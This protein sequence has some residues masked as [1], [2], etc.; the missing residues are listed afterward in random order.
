VVCWGYNFSWVHAYLLVAKEYEMKEVIAVS[1]LFIPLG[2][3]LLNDRVEET[4]HKLD[5][6][7]RGGLFIVCAV[8][9]WLYGHSYFASFFLSIAIFFMFFDYLINII[10]LR[11][12]DWYSFLGTTSEVDKVKFWKDMHPDHRFITRA[13]LFVVCIVWYVLS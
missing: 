8:T 7:I 10:M 6:F 11:R 3:E 12:S 1:F 5:V 4:N 9:P 13:S 2:W